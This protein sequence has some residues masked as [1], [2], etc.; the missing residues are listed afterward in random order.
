MG[1]GFRLRFIGKSILVFLLFFFLYCCKAPTPTP[2]LKGRTNLIVDKL[3]KRSLREPTIRVSLAE[4]ARRLTISSDGM[5]YL[6]DKDEGIFFGEKTLF[7]EAEVKLLGEGGRVIYQI[8]V[9]SFSHRDNGEKAVAEIRSN[10]SLPVSLNYDEER[11]VYQV[12]V[13][14]FKDRD[15]ATKF[16]A[17][18]SRLG[19]SRSFIVSGSL[20]SRSGELLL[21][22]L[23]GGEFIRVRKALLLV[24]RDPS[25]PLVVNGVSYRGVIEV[26][27]SPVGGL[28][29]VNELWLEDYLKGVVPCEMSPDLFPEIEALKAQAVAAR[30]YAVKNL[31]KFASLGFDICSTPRSQVYRGIPAEQELTNEAVIETAG[32]VIAFRGEPINALYTSTC[33]GHTEDVENVFPGES[34]PYLRGVECYPEVN[35]GQLV[36]GEDSLSPIYSEDEEEITEKIILLSLSGVTPERGL[37][38]VYLSQPVIGR[39]VKQFSH[40]SGR[41]I[42]QS[43]VMNDLPDYPSLLEVI[44]FLVDSFGWRRRAELMIGGK[45]LSYIF[46]DDEFDSTDQL[47]LKKAA[48]LIKEKVLTPFP[49]GRYHLSSPPSRGLVLKL[50]YDL[51]SRFGYPWLER[52]NFLNSE[53]GS[54]LLKVKGKETAYPLCSKPYLFSTAGARSIKMDRLRIFLGDELIFHHSNGCIDFIRIVPN[55]EGISD[56]RY[57]PYHS[58]K[59]TYTREELEGRIQ[60]FADLGELIDIIPEGFGVSGRVAKLLVRG[61][62]GER[63][64]YGLNIREVLGLRDTLFVIERSY[65]RE[66]RIKSFT[67]VGKGWGHGVGLCQ[68]GAFGMALRG[69][70]YR[71]ILSH[72]YTGVSTTRIY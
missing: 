14:Q 10:T 63:T 23:P 21:L 44:S 30:T 13:G 2:S 52:G 46:P 39:E 4:G 18:F 50:I 65:D 12:R 27:L 9:G 38:P 32:E 72:Y 57:S 31:G 55:C 69:A 26:Y 28:V 54:L 64:F 59:V 45:D 62:A 53:G 43:D 11:S 15:E 70:S 51:L 35:D 58:W 47:A 33:G 37:S 3:F 61:S 5:F 34:E 40:K 66:G 42:G 19:F 49:D 41:I 60:R 6:V 25:Q 17:E 67:F 56:D 24:P 1:T 16:L 22:L 20:S 68:V 36:T 48:L 29:V 71:D 7:R 8:Q